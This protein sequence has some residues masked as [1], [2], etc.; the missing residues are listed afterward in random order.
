[1]T[2]LRSDTQ[3]A[4]TE[5]LSNRPM[6][7]PTAVDL[8]AALAVLT[9]LPWR[10]PDSH[11]VDYARATIFFPIV[12]AMIGLVLMGLDQAVGPRLSA[13]IGAA[14]VVVS[15][16]L[17]A[18]EW[19]NRSGWWLPL[20]WA[21]K[22]ACLSTLHSTRPAALLFAPILARWGMVVMLTGARDAQHPERKFNP[23]VTFREFAIASVIS[24]AIVCTLAEVVGVVLYV[25]SGGLLL[26]LRL[27]THRF[28]GGVS[29]RSLAFTIQIIEILVLSLLVGLR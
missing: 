6:D 11:R 13:S 8:F 9:P 17:A 5:D 16:A 22:L 29:E 2:W 23:Q 4:E 1:M 12:G 15:W 20:S 28:Y 3:M 10:R 7:R 21:T 25:L 27:L 26:A 19:R 24:G 14:V 18:G